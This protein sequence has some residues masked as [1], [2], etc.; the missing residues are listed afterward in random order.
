[1]VTVT[2]GE[3]LP[4]LTCS[5]TLIQNVIDNLDIIPGSFI[6]ISW[7]PNTIPSL[8][9]RTVPASTITISE[10]FT[11]TDASIAYANVYTCSASIS[12][13]GSNSEYVI[14]SQQPIQDTIILQVKSK[15][16]YCFTFYACT[17]HFIC[18][19]SSNT[20]CDCV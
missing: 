7:S 19:Y 12:Y 11:I 4:N 5:V 6:S 1:M 8:N 9:T 17:I 20:I 15:L 13:N 14:V 2:Q 18:L 10:T 16:A 3:N